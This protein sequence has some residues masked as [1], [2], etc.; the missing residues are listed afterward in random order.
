MAV[1]E[2]SICK[3]ALTRI[4]QD[5]NSLTAL[6]DATKEGRLATVHYEPSRDAVLR[7]H[8]W[9]FA[10]KRADLAQVTQAITAITK[11]NPAV[12]T[13][14]GADS[15]A[16]GDTVAIAAVV[17]MTEMNGR[18]ATVANVNTGANTLE[19]SGIDSTSF[20]T[21]VSGGTIAIAPLFEFA[22]RF[23]LPT[24]CLKVIRTESESAGINAEYR[25][26]GRWISTD[27]DECAI[28]YIAQITDTTQFDALFVDLLAQRLAAEMC[29]PLTS[30]ANL[31][32]K[33][34]SIYN[35]KLAEARGTDSQEG[36]MRPLVA[37]LWTGARL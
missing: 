11:A 2:A 5:P 10:I 24:D 9:N 25:V 26:E 33:L 1:T 16:N 20:T 18:S 12:V 17:G 8:P 13:Y 22:A 32:E 14:S 36:T 29:M 4:G 35:D 37:D 28:E 21:Y 15:F 34:W 3:L 6:A 7:A 19:L 27:D 31:T 30:N 23:P